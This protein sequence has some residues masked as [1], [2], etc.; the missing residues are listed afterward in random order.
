LVETRSKKGHILI[1]TQNNNF[2]TVSAM[3]VT[4]PSTLLIPHI[5]NTVFVKKYAAVPSFI[6]QALAED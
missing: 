6:G 3:T 4:A 1:H 2:T 5:S